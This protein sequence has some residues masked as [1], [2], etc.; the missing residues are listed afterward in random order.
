VR[1]GR[2]HEHAHGRHA[3]EHRDD[4]QADQRMAREL[5]QSLGHIGGEKQ[6]GDAGEQPERN[7][8]NAW[9]IAAR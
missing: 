8:A 1:R 4:D 7:R 3:D 6:C 2:G 5:P 9:I